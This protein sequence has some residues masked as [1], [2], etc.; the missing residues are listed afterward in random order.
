MSRHASWPGGAEVSTVQGQRD[1]EDMRD[2]TDLGASQVEEA[3]RS[4]HAR[5]RIYVLEEYRHRA[6]AIAG[7][8][9]QERM[10][11]RGAGDIGIVADG[12]D[13][14][15]DDLNRRI[16]RERIVMKEIA[17]RGIEVR[18]S[19]EERSWSLHRGD[20]VVFRERVV[21][22]AGEVVRNGEQGRVVTVD[23][24]HRRITVA[25]NSGQR[26]TVDLSA[27]APA[28]PVVPAYAAHVTTCA[29]GETPVVIVSP[30]RHATRHSADT[31]TT[32]AI[33]ELHVV[34][35]RQTFGQDPIDGLIR[36]WSRTTQKPA[37]WSQLDDAARERGARWTAGQTAP[38]DD[39]PERTAGQ[40]PAGRDVDPN[41]D[42]VPMPSVASRGRHAA[43]GTRDDARE[44]R[45]R[46]PAGRHRKPC[47]HD[48]IAARARRGAEA[49]DAPRRGDLGGVGEAI[50]DRRDA[51][52]DDA[53][54]A[55]NRAASGALI[56][57]VAVGPPWPRA[58]FASTG[59]RLE[60]R[61]DAPP[62]GRHH[63]NP[64]RGDA[65][66]VVSPQPTPQR[67]RITNGSTSTGSSRVAQR[68]PKSTA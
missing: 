21:T 19:G 62:R 34:I 36:D 7:L 67:H 38:A 61:R 55:A 27:K 51:E 68:T 46:V 65:S 60:R 47:E 35:D 54:V 56:R 37:A 6:A 24:G 31:A 23:H 39:R 10:R 33:E 25:L 40:H 30:G 41:A 63:R 28:Q 59:D 42:T 53:E 57:D 26:V 8:Y 48:D 15:L 32:R 64:D 2:F 20:R 13:H 45:D 4:L 66:P 16:Q 12:P 3:V 11:G 52:A 14:V 43:P 9:L 17:P 44:R 22:A 18:A 1:T 58:P 29:G 50:R 5:D 49:L